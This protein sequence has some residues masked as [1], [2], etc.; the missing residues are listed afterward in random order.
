VHETCYDQ[1]PPRVQASKPTRMGNAI[2]TQAIIDNY[3]IFHFHEI[4]AIEA[5]NF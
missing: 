5:L 1:H 3:L 4:R 2:V